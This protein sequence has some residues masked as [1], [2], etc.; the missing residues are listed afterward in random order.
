MSTFNRFCIKSGHAL[1][2]FLKI[3]NPWEAYQI[4]SL[5]LHELKLRAGFPSHKTLL[6]YVIPY[7]KVFNLLQLSCPVSVTGHRQMSKCQLEKKENVRHEG[8]LVRV[9]SPTE[10]IVACGVTRVNV[11]L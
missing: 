5:I 2:K 11:K 7:K 9:S 1:I 10:I 3:Q 8:F 6:L 4:T